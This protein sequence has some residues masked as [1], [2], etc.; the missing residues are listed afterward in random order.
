MGKTTLAEIITK[1]LDRSFYTL[2]AI[3]SGVKDLR[4]IID[5][6]KKQGLFG[7]KNAIVFIDEIHRFSKTQQDALLAAVEKGLITLIGATT[8]NPSFEVIPALRSRCQIFVLEHHE[9]NDL[10]KFIDKALLDQHVKEKNPTVK[11]TNALIRFRVETQ[12]NYLMLLNFVFCS[13]TKKI[14]L[15]TMHLFKISFNKI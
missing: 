1:E 4:L 9:T 15:L 8:E 7:Q 2:S 10:L 13:W 12:E 3:N 11:E 14:M 5:Q 6:I